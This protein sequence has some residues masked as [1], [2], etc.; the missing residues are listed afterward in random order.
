MVKE[1][2]QDEIIKG[3]TK[4]I[5]ILRKI[6]AKGTLKDSISESLYVRIGSFFST[7]SQVHQLFQRELKY[8]DLVVPIEE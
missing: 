8:F 3:I 6:L 4:N 5:G 2:N 7:E 1:A